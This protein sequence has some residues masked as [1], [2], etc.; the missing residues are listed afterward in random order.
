MKVLFKVLEGCPHIQTLKLQ[1]NGL[2]I[3]TFNKL[4]AFLAA[5]NCPIVN[6]FVDWNPIYS[7][8]FIPGDKNIEANGE[9]MYVP[10]EGEEEQNPWGK[11]IESNRKLQV[12]FMRSSGLKD[13]DVAHIVTALKSNQ[14]IKVL[15]I[16]SNSGLS[17]SVVEGFAEVMASN[18]TIEY[19]GLSKLGLSNEQILPILES[20]GKFP[21]PED[22]V[23]N[24]LAEIKKRDAIIEK[25]K[26]LKASKKP[27][28]PVPQVDNIEQV[29]KK[30]ENGEDV[31]E[32]VT[33]KNPQ[34]KHLNVC[35]NELD[36][37]V[38]EQF[39]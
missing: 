4:I 19:L 2:T 17:G 31:Q 7:D 15:D 3:S 13:A 20:V 32:W 39:K 16:S 34:L 29:A 9:N 24:Q 5:D 22:Q 38:E 36:D 25:N 18:R 12:L 8:A 28:E 6:L 30:N 11:L 21:F 14:S 37:D 23:E 35:M 10:E 1:N 26:K 33:I 27:E